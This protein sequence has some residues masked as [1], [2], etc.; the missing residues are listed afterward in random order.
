MV[1]LV[2]VLVEGFVVEQTVGVVEADLL[3]ED[4][5]DQLEEDGWPGGQTVGVEGDGGE[6]AV[7][8]GGSER[9]KEENVGDDPPQRGGV[10]LQGRLKGIGRED[11]RQLTSF[12]SW[13]L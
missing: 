9:P 1:D 7:E 5:Y 11:I 12:S 6:E 13:I 8:E 3:D 10:P 4:E 2:D